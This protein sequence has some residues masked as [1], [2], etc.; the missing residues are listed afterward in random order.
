M[1][2][3]PDSVRDLPEGFAALGA[4]IEDNKG[5]IQNSSGCSLFAIG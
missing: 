1:R 5:D 2:F 4:V 3:P